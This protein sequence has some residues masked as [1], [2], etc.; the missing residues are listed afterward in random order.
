VP[1]ISACNLQIQKASFTAL[2]HAIYSA[3]VLD[4]ATTL[5][6]VDFQEIAPLYSR[7]TYPEVD[8]RESMSP[9]QSESVNPVILVVVGPAPALALAIARF[10]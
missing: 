5:C 7:N 8:F 9:A 10:S 6:L 3:L 2:E 4:I 1:L